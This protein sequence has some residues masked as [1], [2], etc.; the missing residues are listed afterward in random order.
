V[1]RKLAIWGLFLLVLYLARDFFFMA[2]MTFL[3][4]Y[5]T[6]SAVGWAMKRL[7]PAGGRPGL[8][9]GLT[10]AFFLCL[11]L[12]VIGGAVLIGPRLL[13]QGQR[14]A[15]WIG[16]VSPET[17]VPRLLEGVVGP[18]EFRQKYP[19]TNGPDYQRDLKDFAANGPRHVAAYHD[20]PTL[21]AW[22]EGGFRKQ[23]TDA[24][25][26][27]IRSRLTRAGTSSGEFEQWFL[28]QKVPEL[29]QQ[30]RKEVPEAGRPSVP[31]DPLVRQAASA[32]PEQL[33]E[34]ARRD[35]EALRVLQQEWISDTLSQDL[36]QALRSPAYQERFRDYYQQQREH[37]PRAVPYTYEEYLA[38]QKARPQ[39]PH[40]FGEALEHLRPTDP[41]ERD[42]RLRADFQAAREHELFQEW[43][44][45]SSAGAFLRKRAAS[46][47]S[48]FGSDRV[49][50]ILTSLLN[51]PLDLVTAL[52][53]TFFICIDFPRLQAGVRR[54]RETW[55]RDVYEEMAP[56][57]SSLAHLI[58]LAFRAQGLIALCNALML[59]IA[60]SWL[61]VEHA[62]LLAAAVFVL[63]L[64]PTL[65]AVI[66][67]VLICVVALIQPGGGPALAAKAAAAVLLV[68]CMESFVLS[69]RI[70][71]RLMELHPA[72]VI[73]ILP[74][75]QYF[76]GVWGLLL[77]T[78]VAVYVIHV[79]ILRRGL[80][81]IGAGHNAHDAEALPP[82]TAVPAAPPEEEVEWVAP[83]KG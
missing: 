45:T 44:S 27:R 15:G 3:F 14:F 74:L 18:Y 21:E 38:L 10:L 79:L 20:F 2:F 75:A 13:E 23:F 61:G 41:S 5:V 83:Q 30:A 57:F 34:Q 70:M 49:E 37:S 33:L 1:G 58:G 11:V 55:L 52:L 48:D 40:A 67:L 82:T 29:K 54:L 81:G 31:V 62:F 69:P 50:H 25:R 80:P 76:F 56:A 6:L 66:A 26:G 59:L 19:D 53:L 78:P 32:T 47:V 51:I 77:A 42:A 60:L 46:G 12:V 17:E 8:H 65:G 28:K 71:G 24:E 73:A 43:W 4:S 72:L 9:R 68:M 35:P 64:V 39:G 22:V 36:A 7:A 63:C 16:Q